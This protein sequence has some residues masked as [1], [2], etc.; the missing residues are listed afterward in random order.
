M[1]KMLQACIESKQAL[2]LVV[3]CL[4]LSACNSS[5][6]SITPPV[7]DT[8]AT[9]QVI[10]I[11]Q[12]SE[13]EDGDRLQSFDLLEDTVIRGAFFT[14]TSPAE[15]PA[16]IR[17]LPSHGKLTLQQ[18]GA[19]FLY[20]PEENYAGEDEFSYITYENN[21]VTVEF[22]IA[23]VNDAPLI[24]ASLPRVAE[25]GR[26]FT[27]DIE[28]IDPDN[29]DLRFSAVGMPNWMQID[30]E[31][32]GLLGLPSQSDTGITDNI[33]FRVTDS[34]GLFSE[35]TGVQFEV[36]DINDAPTLN[37]TQ[38]PKELTGR[39]IVKTSVFPDDLDGDSV[40]LS[41]E[42][43]SF[44]ESEIEGGSITLTALDVN[45]VTEVNLVII[46]TD[47]LG[48]STRK[49]HPLTIYPVTESG[50]GLTLFGSKVSRGVD[51]VF[52]G[53]G[54]GADQQDLF[55]KHVENTIEEIGSDSGIGDHLAAFNM[56]MLGTVSADSGADDND[57][58]DS[59]STAFDSRYN[60]RGIERLI[61][62][63]TLKM[64]EAVVSEYPD[65]DQVVL[66]VNDERY[67]GSG[68]SGGSVAITS[69]FFPEIALHEMG[70]SLVNLADEY[71][72]PSIQETTAFLLF[73]EG[74]Y[75]NVT[76]ITDPTQVP[77]AHWI[78]PS[79][80][81]PQNAGDRR[82]GL[83]Q[84]G[85]YRETGIYRPTYQSRMRVFSSDFGLVNSELWILRLYTITEGI[86]GTAP[87]SDTV[88]LNAGGSQEFVISPMFGEDIQSVE[89]RVNGVLQPFNESDPN[90]LVV[91]PNVGTHTIAVTITDISEKIKLPLPHAGVFT[92][93]W[94]L[95][96][97]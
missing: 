25:Q 29:D 94:E 68:N 15:G 44:V 76:Q 86:R 83:Y 16:I 22:N 9:D 47:R 41:V 58:V 53:D 95:E 91:S 90:R 42:D 77:W 69:A 92:R 65:Y 97:K 19:V 84:G 5:S 20:T 64:L 33:T 11:A 36:I 70:H 8:A 43:N 18:E 63:N 30:A 38:L 13:D 50:K 49:I 75:R 61:C 79:I 52:L 71:V 34:F 82:V 32:G 21:E 23:P 14:E 24:S 10:I 66:L 80:S 39:E 27:A 31:T 12:P 37:L 62:A 81:L 78:D 59:R 4:V 57:D 2:A 56:H 1:E 73:Q 17:S 89:W 46:A 7:D 72:D 6:K 60:C 28:A 74:D 40:T 45:D 93:T 48:R 88:A 87:A 3:S 54:Y 67:G 51:V 35:L 55:R 85:L 96:V 26:V